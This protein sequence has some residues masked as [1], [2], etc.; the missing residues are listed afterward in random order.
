MTESTLRRG[1][2][3]YER[4]ERLGAFDAILAATAVDAGAVAL[5]SGDLA[6]DQVEQLTVVIPDRPGVASLLAGP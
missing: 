6:F 2:D 1:L 3:L 4:H 5:V